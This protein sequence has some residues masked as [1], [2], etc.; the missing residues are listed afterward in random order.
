MLGLVGGT[1]PKTDPLRYGALHFEAEDEV[2]K[3]YLMENT[4]AS[5]TF[6][7]L[8]QCAL[9][10][11]SRNAKHWKTVMRANGINGHMEPNLETQDKR[12][13]FE[14]IMGKNLHKVKEK[15]GD[16]ATLKNMLIHLHEN[17]LD[18]I[19]NDFAGHDFAGNSLD[20]SKTIKQAYAIKIMNRFGNLHQRSGCPFGRGIKAI[21]PRRFVSGTGNFRIE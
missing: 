2:T 18:W 20:Y 11:N 17:A 3:E 9:V 16:K 15:L 21:S 5:E 12:L 10:H 8:G 4:F 7:F 6:S 19:P 1:D 14:E 13:V